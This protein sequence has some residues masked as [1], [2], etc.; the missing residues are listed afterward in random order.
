MI[1]LLLIKSWIPFQLIYY[2]YYAII[3]TLSQEIIY[4]PVI[5]GLENS[6]YK[7]EHL[8]K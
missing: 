6:V 5:K 1:D 3:N 7:P 8:P 4:L 2:F